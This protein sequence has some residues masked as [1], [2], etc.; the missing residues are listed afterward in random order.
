MR[1]PRI[2]T[3][4]VLGTGDGMRWPAPCTS[5]ARKNRFKVCSEGGAFSRWRAFR[6][7]LEKWFPPPGLPRLRISRICA[8]P[9]SWCCGSVTR[10]RHHLG[11]PKRD[12]TS[13][14]AQA[15]L[16]SIGRGSPE[17]GINST[18]MLCGD[19]LSVSPSKRYRLQNARKP[20]SL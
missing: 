14:F 9:A 19:L 7:G 2:W 10:L 8:A 5:P 20:S 12:D 15:L 4:S 18:S 6:V 11:P 16:R 13:S 17:G 1:R 3:M